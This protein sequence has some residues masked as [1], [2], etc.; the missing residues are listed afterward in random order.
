MYVTDGSLAVTL[1]SLA[2]CG[3]PQALVFRVK[4][5]HDCIIVTNIAHFTSVLTPYTLLT[6]ILLLFDVIKVIDATIFSACLVPRKLR[7]SGAKPQRRRPENFGIELQCDLLQRRK[8]TRALAYALVRAA[9]RRTPCEQQTDST[10][11]VRVLLAA[12]DTPHE[13]ISLLLS[14]SDAPSEFRSSA[15]RQQL[16]RPCDFWFLFAFFLAG[17]APQAFNFQG[18]APRAEEARVLYWNW[19]AR[20]LLGWVPV[21]TCPAPQGQ[22]VAPQ[23]EFFRG[24]SGGGQFGGQRGDLGRKCRFWYSPGTPR[25]RREEHFGIWEVGSIRPSRGC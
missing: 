6:T 10:Q 12:C 21:G 4:W 18:R 19:P 9:E 15:Q 24:G 5:S 17:T 1:G 14:T 20:L 25:S 8:R 3:W 13:I 23:A 16:R 2:V 22:L 7:A 11:H